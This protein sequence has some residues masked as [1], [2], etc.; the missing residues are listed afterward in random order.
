MSRCFAPLLIGLVAGGLCSVSNCGATEVPRP[1]EL[2]ARY[3]AHVEGLRTFS[4]DTLQLVYEKGGLFPDWT[5]DWIIQAHFAR[6][7][8]RWKLRY[9][10]V[11]FHFYDRVAPINEVRE[12]VFD[13]RSC[14]M[15]SR[16]DRGVRALTS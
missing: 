12:D 13:G 16:D 9:H 15:V 5:W 4:F 11:G 8:D 2:L 14:F 7:G 6:A 1:E 3:E 10:M